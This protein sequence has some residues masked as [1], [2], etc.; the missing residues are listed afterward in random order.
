MKLNTPLRY[1]DGSF[2]DRYG[3]DL[4]DEEYPEIICRANAHDGLL[5]ACKALRLA[6][7]NMRGEVVVTGTVTAATLEAMFEAD[8][9]GQAA[10]AAAEVQHG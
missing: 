7:L 9:L 3:I 2:Q 10:I 1:H 4:D 5:E 6:S 8:D